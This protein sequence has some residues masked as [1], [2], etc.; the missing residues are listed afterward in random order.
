MTDYLLALR[1]ADLPK[2][3]VPSYRANCRNCLAE[4]WVSK[5]SPGGLP[6]VCVDCAVH[7]LEQQEPNQ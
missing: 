6:I 3:Y 2:P 4:V 5:N 1:T 7:H